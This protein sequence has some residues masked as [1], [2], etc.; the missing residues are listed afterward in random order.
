MP[1]FLVAFLLSVSLTVF[2]QNT[3]LN[4]AVSKHEFFSLDDTVISVTCH[5][6]EHPGLQ[7]AVY[8]N[9]AYL[10]VLLHGGINLE[11]I[12]DIRITKDTVEIGDNLYYG[13]IMIDLEKKY[14]PKFISVSDL[15]CKHT[16]LTGNPDLLLIDGELISCNFNDCYID[17]HFIL[18]IDENRIASASDGHTITIV[19]LITRTEKNVRKANKIYIRGTK[20][21]FRNS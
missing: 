18:K 2:A 12:A 21:L 15:I 5:Q 9:G 14:Q 7:P 11:K 4:S 8:I 19:R 10:N 17:E 6:E 20:D 16:G 1:H 3:E 13:K